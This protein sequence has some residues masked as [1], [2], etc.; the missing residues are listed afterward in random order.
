MIQPETPIAQHFERPRFMRYAN[1]RLAAA[2]EIP[3]PFG[4]FC[5][6]GMVSR[7]QHFS[8]D[9]ISITTEKQ[10]IINP[11]KSKAISSSR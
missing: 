3:Y 4:T 9:Q 10:A 2:T 8:D 5:E 1:H 7:S 11:D 6:D